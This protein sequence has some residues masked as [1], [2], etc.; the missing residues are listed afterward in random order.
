MPAFDGAG[1]AVGALIGAAATWF[2]LTKIRKP[3]ASA[4]WINKSYKKDCAK[5]VETVE[6]EDATKY[7]CRCWRSSKM[8]YCDGA[9]AKHNEATGD[10][11]GPVAVKKK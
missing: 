2:Y 6:I 1:L 9:H 11:V 3:E 10:N 7:L 5:C 8:P 4:D